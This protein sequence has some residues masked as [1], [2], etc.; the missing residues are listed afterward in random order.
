MDRVNEPVSIGESLWA[1]LPELLRAEVNCNDAL[2]DG[3]E[4]SDP[5]HATELE[6]FAHSLP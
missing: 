2:T 4:R 5:V 6:L 3:I 1:L